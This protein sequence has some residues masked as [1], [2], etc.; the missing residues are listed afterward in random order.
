MTKTESARVINATV[1]IDGKKGQGVLVPR[2]FIVTAAHCI[3]WDGDGGMAMGDHYLEAVTT[4][5][6]ARFHVGP[7]AAEPVSDIAILGPLDDQTFFDDCDDFEQWCEATPAVPVAKARIGFREPLRV[8]ILSHKDKWIGAS[9][10]NYNSPLNL[11]HG[12]LCIEADDPVECGTSGGPVVDSKGRLVGVVSHFTEQAMR[13][14]YVG[15][16]PILH[17]ALPRWALLLIGGA[18]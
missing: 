1:R 2:G 12:V 15:M 18:A 13:G 7:H 8:S 6:G 9:I 14:K 5:S 4:K 16:L 3:K 11:L 17:L 10:V